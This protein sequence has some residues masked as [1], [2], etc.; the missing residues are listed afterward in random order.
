MSKASAAKSKVEKEHPD[1]T[2]LKQDEIGLVLAKALNE[3]YK[4]S[5][6]NPID[7]F[8]KWLLNHSKTN[9]KVMKEKEHDKHV[10]ELREANKKFILEKQQESEEL[11]KSESQKQEKIQEFYQMLEKSEDLTDNLDELAA[12]LKEFTGATG[13][14]IGRLVKPRIDI[15]DDDDD[16]AHIDEENPKVVWYIHAT[17]EHSFMKGSI[18][19]SDQ[20]ITHDAFKEPELEEEAPVDEELEEGAETKPKDNDIL[21]NFRHIYVPEVVRE[22]RMHFYKV[23]R[24]GSYMAIPLIFQS[25]LFESALDKAVN[26]YLEVRVELEAQNKAKAEY[27]EL[28]QQIREEKEKNGE[29]YEPEEEKVWDVI[30]EEPFEIEIEEYVICFDTLGQDRQFTDD[31]RRFALETVLNFKNIWE[32]TEVENLT[33]DRNRKLEIMEL[34][35]EFL[36]NEAQKLM[37][38]EE[39]H[40]DEII[41]AREEQMD[42]E[43]RDLYMRQARLTFIG[44][45][46]KDRDDWRNNLM[47]LK[48]FKVLKMPRVMQSIFYLLQYRREDICERGTNKFFW[49]KA[50]NLIDEDFIDR[51]IYFNAL[52]PKE[53]NYERY[54]TLNFI[55]RNLTDFNPE[56]V[57]AYN[58]CLGKLF[59]WSL[60]AIK[61]RKD[62]I[63]R[64]KALTLKARENRETIIQAIEAREVKRGVDLQEAEDKFKEEHKD[65]IEAALKY[66][67]MENEKQ[68]DEYGDEEADEDD[69]AS[70]DKMPKEKPVMPEFNADEFL[71]KWVEDNP[72]PVLTEEVISDIDNDWILQEE[73]EEALIQAYFAAKEQN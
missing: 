27:E 48:E 10:R 5:P 16:K 9:I 39:K 45:L 62:D 6:N 8:A 61:T 63:T 67:Q 12:F 34:D 51:L 68:E 40:I 15:T 46:Y 71:E 19:K 31:E 23:P 56:D 52:G 21:T 37:D 57:D 42:D 30:Q 7:F 2:Y 66:E 43:L 69:L 22:P 3:T 47:T 53:E 18:L 14:Y 29:I 35:K 55:E 73:E 58:L 32:R 41:N 64:R 60:L 24:L 28:Q 70:K 17:E 25:C 36:D 26:N 38:E 13:V 20:G 44:R 59:K 1:I 50:K 4:A 72:E 11:V 65:E 49:K 54:Q 33:R